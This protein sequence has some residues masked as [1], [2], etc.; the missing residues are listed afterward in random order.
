MYGKLRAHD[1]KDDLLPDVEQCL[2]RLEDLIQWSV[3]IGRVVHNE[4]GFENLLLLAASPMLGLPD[5]ALDVAAL[6]L[7]DERL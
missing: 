5:V 7:D 4:D 2:L 3:R 1:V 6:C